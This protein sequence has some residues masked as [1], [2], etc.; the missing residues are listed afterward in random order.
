MLVATTSPT[1]VEHL[2]VTETQSFGC[3]SVSSKQVGWQIA[4]D[5]GLQTLKRTG[6]LR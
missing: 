5:R 6:L 3:A 2:V 4:E 1:S